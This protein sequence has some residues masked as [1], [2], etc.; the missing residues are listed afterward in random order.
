M[1]DGAY[2]AETVGTLFELGQDVFGGG[3]VD[4]DFFHFAHQGKQVGTEVKRG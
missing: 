2:L 4:R 3:A 1:R